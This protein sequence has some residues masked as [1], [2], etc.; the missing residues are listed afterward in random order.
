MRSSPNV[1]TPEPS[2]RG[3]VLKLTRFK[4]DWNHRWLVVSGTEAMYFNS[5]SDAHPKNRFVYV[6]IK[7][8]EA[9]PIANRYSF[10]MT[11][12]D[13]EVLEFACDT[14]AACD[15]WVVYCRRQLARAAESV[16]KRRSITSGV[17][18][19]SGSTLLDDIK[20]SLASSLGV[21]L[22]DWVVLSPPVP[23]VDFNAAELEA[24]LDEDKDDDERRLDWG[25]GSKRG[26][27]FSSG[28]GGS[29]RSSGFSTVPSTGGA[30]ETF[31]IPFLRSQS[32]PNPSSERCPI[33][34]SGLR[35]AFVSVFVSLLRGYRE[36]INVPTF[37][38]PVLTKHDSILS[39]DIDLRNPLASKS[40]I[41]ET[42]AAAAFPSGSVAK[43]H[44][45]GAQGSFQAEEEHLFDD[46][47][48][49]SFCEPDYCKFLAIFLQTQMF[50]SFIDER[51]ELLNPDWFEV[52]VNEKMKT[53]SANVKH[54][55]KK[56]KHGILFKEGQE[57]KTWNQRWFLLEEMRLEVCHF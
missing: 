8:M 44:V 54:Y 31:G 49:L 52:A 36:F 46:K 33:N 56:K 17:Q 9:Q 22:S 10:Q 45:P 47:A 35:K 4:F 5:L 34:I 38:P 41:S 48:F 7:P 27:A 21:G 57:I 25:G 11:T 42:L 53:I 14:Q 51:V 6:K 16:V 40:P 20:S 18:L 39:Q 26:S 30:L 2:K 28:G 19:D 3:Q 37:A 24:P 43:K 12:R 55:A 13:L 50:Q 15:E 29:K 1:E 32:A 23:S